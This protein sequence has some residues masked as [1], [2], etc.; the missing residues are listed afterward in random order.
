MNT[1]DLIVLAAMAV[2]VAVALGAF[3][4]ITKY[5]FDRGLVDRNQQAPNIIDFYKT[6]VAHTRKT[7]GRI[8]TAFWVHAVSAGLFIVIGVG[9]TIF[10]FI[11]P[12]LG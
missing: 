8:G 9:Y 5:L 10:R 1:T 7:T 4:P 6:Y 2:V 3:V 12:R 11:L